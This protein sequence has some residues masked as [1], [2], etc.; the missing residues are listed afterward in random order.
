MN[1]TISLLSLIAATTCVVACGDD[2]N[3]GDG[4][5]T[6]GASS[7]GASSG[8]SAGDDGSGGSG[9]DSGSGSGG[10][11]NSGECDLS[12]GDKEEAVIPQNP[13]M[14]LTSDKVWLL[15]GLTYV[16]EGST[17][18]IEPC[19]RI[20][21]QPEGANGNS[22]LVVS[23]GAKIIA[24]GEPDAPILFTSWAEEGERRPG[25]WGGIVILGR[26]PNNQGSVNIEGLDP[27]PKYQ[28]GGDDP[29][30][31]SGVIK[32]VRIEFPGVEIAPDNE[33]NGI[34]FGSVG[35]GTEVHHVMVSNALDDAFEW[36]GGTVNAHHLIAH[37]ADDDMFDADQGYNGEIHT[38]FGRLTRTDV[39]SR[40]PNGWECDNNSSNPD[41]E[42]VTNVTSSKVTL[43]GPGEGLA[44]TSNG[45][46][47][48]RGVTG[49]FT[50]QVFLGW[51]NGVS[52]RDPAG[53]AEEP[54]VLLTDS[55][56]FEN[57]VNVIGTVHDSSDPPLDPVEWF[58]FEERG[59][60]VPDEPPF[61]LS[62]C[63][64]ADGPGSAVTGSGLGAFK[65]EAD[66]MQGLWV[67]WSV[68]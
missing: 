50:D 6:G 1:R 66:W 64:A 34:T 23:R 40:D 8:G 65:D 61:E 13:D 52:L 18:T 31:D 26:A 24:A 59:N 36:F 49:T 51:H 12:R 45:A 11:M 2:E 68:D 28:H 5:N 22:V 57:H 19:T 4:G 54:R 41:L 15:D 10:R 37:N 43:C 3:G 38:L 7:G 56:F 67:D 16:E 42:P 39:D 32:Y 62:D 25:D 9:N 29:D 58:E 55:T 44:T 27:D 63:L 60:E 14:T 20:E 17:L 46:V 47:F 48:R 21:G 33:I 30:D 35:R 53:T